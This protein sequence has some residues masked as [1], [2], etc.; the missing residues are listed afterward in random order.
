MGFTPLLGV[1]IIGYCHVQ[2][3][4]TN[5]RDKVIFIKAKDFPSVCVVGVNVLKQIEY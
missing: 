5:N 3:I 2:A 1:S 4:Y